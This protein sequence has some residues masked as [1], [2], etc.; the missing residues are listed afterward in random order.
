[1]Q[2]ALVYIWEIVFAYYLGD[3]KSDENR[4]RDG[5]ENIADEYE[6][7]GSPAK[8]YAKALKY[9]SYDDYCEALF[10][11]DP[12]IPNRV[13]DAYCRLFAKV[14]LDFASAPSNVLFDAFV[15]MVDQLPDQWLNWL[16]SNLQQWCRD[17]EIA[18]GSNLPR[19]LSPDNLFP[20]SQ[21]G[22]AGTRIR[23]KR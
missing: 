7:V 19:R 17:A 20:W 6:D 5:D 4:D 1:L 2:R 21:K 16:R 11:K 18:V 14:G 12:E 15:T 22:Q 3:L 10:E 13:Y 23:L 8:E 9:P